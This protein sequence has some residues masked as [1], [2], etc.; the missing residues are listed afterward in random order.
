M[1]YEV[2]INIEVDDES[3]RLEVGDT[4]NLDTITKLIEAAL[5]DIDDLEIEEIDVVRRLD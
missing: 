2:V 1:K 4:S 5:Y 3:N